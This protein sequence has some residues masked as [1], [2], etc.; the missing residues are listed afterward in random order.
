MT[1]RAAASRLG[2]NRKSI[3]QAKKAGLR[4]VRIGRYDLVLGQWLWDFVEGFKQN[5]SN[6]DQNHE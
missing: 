3:V 6:Q 4:T 2:W 1:L 5:S